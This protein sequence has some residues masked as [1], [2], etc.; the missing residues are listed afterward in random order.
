[1][2]GNAFPDRVRSSVEDYFNLELCGPGGIPLSFQ[3]LQFLW[4]ELT[5]NCERE[6]QHCYNV[7][8]PEGMKQL[9]QRLGATD[10]FMN[11][12]R[13]IDVLNQ[14]YLLGCRAVQFTGG[15]ATTVPYLDDLVAHAKLLGYEFIEVFTNCST[16]PSWDR[17]L[18]F[19][20]MGVN[21][22]TSFYSA[23]AAVHA[24]VVNKDDWDWDAT[25]EAIVMYLTA[26]LPFRI[27]FIEMEANEG[28]FE[29]AVEFLVGLGIPR[30][31]VGYDRL[32]GIGR[33]SREKNLSDTNTNIKQLCGQCCNGKMAVLPSGH[34]TACVFCQ[35]SP[36][37]TIHHD[38]VIG[39][40]TS[41][42]M[43][44]L[45]QKIF[46]VA[47]KPKLGPRPI[48]CEP[49]CSPKNNPCYPSFIPKMEW[50]PCPPLTP[51]DPITKPDIVTG[52]DCQPL[53]MAGAYVD[54]RSPI[55]NWCGPQCF[56]SHFKAGKT[57]YG[58]GPDC[59]PVC[60]PFCH[61]LRY[62]AGCD[63]SCSPGDWCGPDDNRA[64]VIG[65]DC[66]P[67][68]MAGAYV[69]VRSACLPTDGPPPPCYPQI[70]PPIT[71]I[72]RILNKIEIVA[73]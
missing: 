12:R 23:N 53:F 54:V 6:C 31:N 3:P 64:I 70:K 22:A 71:P 14:A 65:G 61:P 43:A 10:G 68:F 19:K 51:C 35:K 7:S 4:C 56:P 28:H 17:V 73:G 2:A 26:G 55:A 49:S 69:D 66:Q 48:P 60:N 52:G 30:E 40:Y 67:L 24:K 47:L 27:G 50:E 59:S 5:H 58:C 62:T 36:V 29:S 38:G 63:P 11:K 34:I 72:R 13:W 8:G 33:G 15:E 16:V 20:R 21:I 57:N 9:A 45:R 32:R 41:R 44:D 42:N 1:M 39:A 18:F 25:V 46:E 37:G